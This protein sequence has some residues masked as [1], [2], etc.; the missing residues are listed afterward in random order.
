[1]SEKCCPFCGGKN[2]FVVEESIRRE[3]YT[4][5]E[6]KD[7]DVGPETVIGDTPPRC[8]DC[9]ELVSWFVHQLRGEKK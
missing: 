8:M 4:T 2:G 5:W 9:K 3:R 7:N 6:D 1:M